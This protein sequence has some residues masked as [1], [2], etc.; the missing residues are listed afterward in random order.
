MPQNPVRLGDEVR[1]VCDGMQELRRRDEHCS[2]QSRDR[3]DAD[4][5]V[6]GGKDPHRSAKVEP[7]E[8]NGAGPLQFVE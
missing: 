1:G 4:K 6:E 5:S 7:P 8:G 2:G 3:H